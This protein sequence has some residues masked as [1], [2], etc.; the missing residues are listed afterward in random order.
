MLKYSNFEFP[1]LFGEIIFYLFK[2]ILKNCTILAD[3]ADIKIKTKAT[4]EVKLAWSLLRDTFS[5]ES[6]IVCGNTRE[7]DPSVSMHRLLK[8]SSK[9][10]EWI[11]TESRF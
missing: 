4:L 10:D 11:K 6:C 9:K 2:H 3:S 7:K 8:E 5:I 1:S